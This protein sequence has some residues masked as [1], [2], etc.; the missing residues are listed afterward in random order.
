M[1]QA[2]E[3]EKLRSAQQ[4][5]ERRRNLSRAARNQPRETHKA[6]GHRKSGKLLLERKGSVSRLASLNAHKTVATKWKQKSQ[7]TTDTAPAVQRAA[8]KPSRAFEENGAEATVP[9]RST[10]VAKK[11]DKANTE[12][13]QKEIVSKQIKVG[14]NTG[15][16]AELLAAIRSSASSKP[17]KAAGNAGRREELLTATHSSSPSATTKSGGNGGGRGDLLAAIRNGKSLK[18][19]QASVQRAS[20]QGRV[21]ATKQAV[22]VKSGSSVVNQPNR[23]VPPS[24]GNGALLAAIRQ[25]T[26]LKKP[27]RK[28]AAEAPAPGGGAPNF[29][30]DIR[31]GVK[32]AKASPPA[33]SPA[34]PQKIKKNDVRSNLLDQIKSGRQILKKAPEKAPTKLQ[35]SSHAGSN[36]VAEILA[37]RMA[38]LGSAGEI[39]DSDGSDNSWDEDSTDGT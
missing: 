8:L 27:E 19:T 13:V 26:T 12:A 14:G 5:A 25:G 6:S 4:D 7:R 10:A 36:T 28:E 31:A 37:R 35:K 15:G 22:P 30:A 24:S 3:Q 11:P 21:P 20:V 1:K 34:K 33:S 38:I 9:G 32:L 29:L 17:I 2:K 18:S 23:T 39:S 16:R